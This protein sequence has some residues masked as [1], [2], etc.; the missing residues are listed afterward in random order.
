V[1]KRKGYIMQKA[2]RG[3]GL[4]FKVE[5]FATV[6]KFEPGTKIKYGPNPKR[7][8]S[9]SFT[10][11]AK[12]QNA[13][14]VGESLKCGAKV[15]DF[16]WELE[17]GD[18]KV[19][20][21]VRPEAEEVRAIGRAAY[22]RCKKAFSSFIGPQGLMVKLDD[23]KAAEALKKE[24]AWREQKLKRCET[25]AKQMKLPVET[26]EEIEAM[27]ESG[28]IRIQRRVA[29]ALSEQKLASGKKIT[30]EDVSEVLG[31]WGFC[32]NTGRVNVL[33]KGVKYVY[34]DTIGAIRRR[35]GSFGITPPT[36]RYRNFPRLLNK[37]LADN[38]PPKL[39]CKFVCTAININGNYAGKRH[40]DANNEGPSVIRAFGK[41]TGGRLRYWP[42]DVRKPGAGSAKSRPQ[43]EALD[44]KDSVTFNLGQETAVF[45]GNRAHEVEAFDGDR[46]SIVFF[47]AR[48]YSRLQPKDVKIA[49]QCGFPWPTPQ[50]LNKLKRSTATA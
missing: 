11:Y 4:K 33:P 5:T 34:S 25:L 2:Q 37:W 35:T 39:G 42:K 28:D 21:G 18:Y 14:T 13:K 23:P 36:S 17:R 12:Y 38:K 32:Q 29:D 22:D 43:V 27:N 24:E 49:K 10:R 7:P 41:F 48:G 40:R 45:D 15:A 19:L 50:E 26:P 31:L 9:K 6:S 20:G 30:S 44:A 46:Y 3:S 47:T 16:L 8:D 1:Q